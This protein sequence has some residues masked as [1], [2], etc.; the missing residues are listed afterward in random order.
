LGIKSGAKRSEVELFLERFL[1]ILNPTDGGMKRWLVLRLRQAY[2]LFT[3][4]WR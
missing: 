4:C 3:A 2:A 1:I